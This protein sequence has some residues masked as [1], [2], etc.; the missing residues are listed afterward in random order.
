[1]SDYVLQDNESKGSIWQWFPLLL[2]SS[3]TRPGVGLYCDDHHYKALY[4]AIENLAVP[5]ISMP[6]YISS[7]LSA[8]VE[9]LHPAWWPA[10]QVP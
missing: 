5:V 10:I 2:Q 7:L 6:A 4:S 3:L 9:Y 1:M 8:S